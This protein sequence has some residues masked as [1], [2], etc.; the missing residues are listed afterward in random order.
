[1][2]SERARSEEEERVE[3]SLKAALMDCKKELLDQEMVVNKLLREIRRLEEDLEGY[4]E[5]ERRYEVVIDQL[6]RDK[7]NIRDRITSK[8]LSETRSASKAT[9]ST[10]NTNRGEY[11]S[12]EN[13]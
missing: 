13:L 6:E 12:K 4:V 7:E 1:M 2:N 10:M 11:E 3:N 5:R 9:L 8:I